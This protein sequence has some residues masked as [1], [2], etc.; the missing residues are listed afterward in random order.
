[1]ILDIKSSFN[2]EDSNTT[3]KG[4]QSDTYL[5]MF[6]ELTPSEVTFTSNVLANKAFNYSLTKSTLEDYIL[7]S[8]L[9]TLST[10]SYYT[11]D[12]FRGI[13]VNIGVSR[14]SIAGYGQ[15]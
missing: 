3:I 5:T 6:R 8:S 2:L 12:M 13:I 1:L 9:Y 15:F 4:E 14:K 11:L 7:D 10:S